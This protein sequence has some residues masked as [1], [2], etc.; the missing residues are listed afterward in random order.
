MDLNELQE[1]YPHGSLWQHATY[2]PG[3]IVGW[4][5]S[6]D[7]PKV[8]IRHEERQEDGTRVRRSYNARP[9]VIR[10][11]PAGVDEPVVG[12]RDQWVG[13]HDGIIC[14][15]SPS[16]EE[17][18]RYVSVSRCSTVG[19]IVDGVVVIEDGAAPSSTE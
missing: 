17:A 19:R 18:R 9:N 7:H 10:W 16:E 12:V 3:M 2:G 1:L 13:I 5:P 4:E 11:V 6:Q 14:H 8:V 15:A